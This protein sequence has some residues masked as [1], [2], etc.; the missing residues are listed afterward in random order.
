M[1]AIYLTRWA[2]VALLLLPPFC[3]AQ[4]S[5]PVNKPQIPSEADS[6]DKFVPAGWKIEE[7]LAADLNG[8]V[9]Q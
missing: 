6:I 9:V 5:N 4:E 7:Q 8:D 3:F 1:R 2:V